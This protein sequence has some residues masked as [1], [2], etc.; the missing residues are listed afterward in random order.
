MS[1][2]L[3]LIHL[4][5]LA[6]SL[7]LGDPVK[8]QTFR[9][10]IETIPSSTVSGALEDY[11]GG[12]R[13]LGIGFLK[14]GSY[15]KTLFV[16]SPRSHLTGASVVPLTVECLIPS[17]G[18]RYIEGDLYLPHSENAAALLSRLPLTIHIGAL[19]YKGFGRCSLVLN[20]LAHCCSGETT[21]SAI[22]FVRG[23][24]RGRVREPELDAFGITVISARYGYLTEPD[25]NNRRKA[26]YRRAIMEGSLVEAPQ[27][28]ISE[29]YKYD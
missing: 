10:C 14:Q 15:S 29:E 7:V 25:P 9:P 12:S 8:R 18:T 17:T 3:K 24:F 27:V 6:E 4:S 28:F 22:P 21:G 1:T 11:S 20:R 13:I 5:L 26:R 2:E 16:H 19:R 23:F